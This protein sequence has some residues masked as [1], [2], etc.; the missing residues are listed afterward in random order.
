MNK[1]KFFLRIFLFRP[2]YGITI[3]L[4]LMFGENWAQQEK[5]DYPIQPIAFTNVR[6]EDDFWERR[7]ETNREVT[8]PYTFQK[9]EET[10]RINNFERAAGLEEGPFEGIFFNDSD[11]FKIIEGA[12][13]SLQVHPDDKLK[14]YLDDLI[15]KIALAQEDDGYLYTNRTIDPSKA[16]DKGGKNRWTNLETFHELYNVGHLYEAA[17]AHYEATGQRSLLDVAIKNADLVEKVFGPGKNMGVP[18]HQEIEM[19]LVKLYRVTGDDKYLNLAKFF[20][21]QRGNAKGHNLYGEY[22]QDAEPFVKQKKAV[23]HSVRAGYFYSGA[24]DIAAIKGTHEYDS[25]L[26]SIWDNIIDTKIYLTGGIGAEPKHEG[27]GPDYELP[28]ATAYT[29]T[30][31]AI[32]LMFWNHRLFLLDGDVK[33]MD[34]FERTLYNGFL[35]GVSF[36]GNTFFYPNPLEADGFSTFNQGVCGRS[37]WFDC[38]CCPVNVVR[39]LPSLPGYIYAVKDEEVYV[40]LFIGSKADVEVDDQILMINQK[41][42]YPWDGTIEFTFDNKEEVTTN[43]KIRVPGWLRGEVMPGNLYEYLEKK[44]LK[45]GLSVNGERQELNM[46]NGYLDLGKRSWKAG[47]HISLNF[48]MAVRQVVA[49]DKV[50]ANRGKIAMERGPLVYC[51]EEVDNPIGV[52]SLEIPDKMNLEYTFDK[53]L[54]E[55]LG[56]ITG[57]FQIEGQNKKITAIPYF[58]WAHREMGEM[59]V[60]LNSK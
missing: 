14:K 46:N 30:C 13:Y 41:T 51:A 18:G 15:A 37:P 45:V 11:V 7:L 35:S 44:D 19:G 22:S 1:E 32:S 36:E 60:W 55:G 20:I 52:L 5:Q 4:F 59:A 6:I 43:L 53:G 31:A 27:F 54:L 34:V 39:V 42:N 3:L 49:N 24:T 33:Y 26:H 29:E 47:D 17:V 48:Q 40:N 28:N 12:S 38:S 10:G 8:I 50:M 23:G 56:K 2:D 58:A 9:S 16:A 25:S 21:D 57:T